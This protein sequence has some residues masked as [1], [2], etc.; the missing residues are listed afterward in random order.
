MKKHEEIKES[1]M[2][3]NETNN[4]NLKTKIHEQITKI[5]IP[6]IIVGIV[7]VVL[8]IKSAVTIGSGQAGVLYKTFSGGVVTEE[9][10]MGEGFHI[11]APWNKV[12]IY[13]VRQQEV[14]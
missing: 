10:P 7:L 8:I 12:F 13:E 3:K 14:F 6:G 4:I 5:A 9:P 2:F 1:F 11:V